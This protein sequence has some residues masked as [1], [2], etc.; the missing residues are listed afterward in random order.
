MKIL[1]LGDI[2]ADAG[3]AVVAQLLPEIVDEH[4]PDI[5]VAQAENVTDGRGMS[6][7]DMRQLQSIGIDFFTGGNWTGYLD[8]IHEVLQDP[9]EPVIGPA[10]FEQCPGTGYKY[11]DTAK[12]KVL[13]ITILGQTVGKR[14][15]GVSN[16]LHKLDEI[17]AAESQRVK[18]VATIVNFHGDFSSEKRI[19]GYYLDGKVSAVIGD[20]WHVPTA[21]A[22]ILPAGTAHITDVG[23]CGSLHNSLGVSLESVIPRWHESKMTKNIQDDSKPW[24]LNAVLVTTD[25]SS[26]L[27]TAI[28]QIQKQVKA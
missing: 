2:M 19:I 10:N 11:L 13:F 1:Y 3:K 5:V 21:D 6:V 4:Q 20:H 8:D 25:E 28:E 27:A 26:G 18:P 16:P 22:M 15:E 17:L 23:M 7:Q 9:K 24:Q 14:L 12:G